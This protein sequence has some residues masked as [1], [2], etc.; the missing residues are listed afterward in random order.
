MA[1]AGTENP[2]T[3][4]APNVNIPS[5]FA[6]GARSMGPAGY[7]GGVSFGPSMGVASAQ[8]GMNNALFGRLTAQNSLNYNLGMAGQAQQ[9]NRMFNPTGMDYAGLGVSGLN[10]LGNLGM[11]GILFGGGLPPGLPP[12]PY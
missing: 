6:Q 11:N 1:F 9:W 3:Y 5:M 2:F 4:S 12:L 10:A 8:Q 7:P